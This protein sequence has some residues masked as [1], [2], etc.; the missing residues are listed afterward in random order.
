MPWGRTVTKEMRRK[1]FVQRVL[2]NEKSKSA[3]CREYGISR[4]T[5]DKWL[6]RYLQ[7]ET[8]SDQSHTPK[9][10]HR[11][12]ETME[13]YIVTMRQ[14]YPAIGAVKLRR[15]LEDEGCTDLP[16]AKTFNNIF[17]RHGLIT[18]EASLAATPYQRFQR[19]EPNEMWQGDYKGHFAM[20]NGQRCHPLNIIDDCTRFN[21]CTEPQLTETFEEIQPVMIRL[22]REFGL[23]AS[24]LCD[25]GNPWGTVQSTGFTRF[26]VWLMELGVLTLH[27]RIHHPQTQGKEESYNR[28]FTREFLKYVSIADLEDAGQKFAAYRQFYNQVRPHLALDLDVPAKHYHRSAR[29]FPDRIEPWDYDDGC[30]LRR[31][32]ENGYFSYD[33]QGYFLSEAFAGKE[34]AVRESHLPGQIT[35]LFRQFRIGRIDVEKRVFTL[36]R[37]YLL[38]GD[39][40]SQDAQAHQDV[41]V[42][43]PKID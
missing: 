38:E 11:T 14:Q 4:P 27:G 40:R 35:L 39:P 36:K 34:I 30:E 3:L 15:M 16:C 23:P 26:E 42:M 10:P 6:K 37:A 12:Q 25:N 41:P 22:F 9:K 8:M 28:S 2:A 32:R 7:G 29:Q 17:Q 31:V 1:E 13:Q 24:F 21:L 33:G 5:G 18:K 43:G 20:G 19:N